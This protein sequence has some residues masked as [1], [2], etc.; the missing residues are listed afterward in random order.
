MIPETLNALCFKG[1]FV[2]LKSKRTYIMTTMQSK[3]R[4]KTLFLSS[5]TFTDRHE[6]NISQAKVC[7]EEHGDC[8][9]EF[10]RQ[11]KDLQ[12]RQH[13]QNQECYESKD[14]KDDIDC[15]FNALWC[16]KYIEQ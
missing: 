5:F 6:G 1:F 3:K 15:P 2:M 13:Q 8:D 10:C 16:R 11:L 14:D 9:K 12:D 7:Q 4:A